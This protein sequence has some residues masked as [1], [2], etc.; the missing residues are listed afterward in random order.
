MRQMLANRGRL[1]HLKR[2]AARLQGNPGYLYGDP[3][4]VEPEHVAEA[5]VSPSVAPE[6]VE[7]AAVASVASDATAA[8]RIADYEA[9]SMADKANVTMLPIVATWNASVIVNPNLGKISAAGLNWF[10]QEALLKYAYEGKVEI[11]APADSQGTATILLNA[12]TLRKPTDLPGSFPGV[13]SV[14]FF[15]FTIASSQLNA[16]TGGNYTIK[17]AWQDQNSDNSGSEGTW[18]DE[19][20]FQRI[21]STEAIYG[22]FI[23]FKVVATRALPVLPL[24]GQVSEALGEYKCI[25]KVGGMQTGDK[26]TVTVPG[27]ATN[28][29]KQI[30]SMY[31]LPAGLVK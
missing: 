21:S 6:V 14:P 20:S 13:R 25:I 28:E 22:V 7:A 18:T 19:Y 4:N 26:L 3:I 10:L 11:A 12:S 1:Q 24:F 29:M 27:Y 15:R 9:M 8:Q 31:N 17:V 2:A 30:A 23:P 5:L 16:A